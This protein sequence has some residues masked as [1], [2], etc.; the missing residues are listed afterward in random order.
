MKVQDQLQ[1]QDQRIKCGWNRIV[2]PI[3]KQWLATAVS[4]SVH[5]QWVSSLQ[6][7]S[8]KGAVG[9]TQLKSFYPYIGAASSQMYS[10]YSDET[11]YLLELHRPYMALSSFKNGGLIDCLV[12]GCSSDTPRL[13]DIESLIENAAVPEGADIY[14]M[15]THADRVNLRN[16]L[17]SLSRF[18]FKSIEQEVKMPPINGDVTTSEAIM[19][20]G[21]TFNYLT[22]SNQLMVPVQGAE[23]PPPI[24]QRPETK[25]A[26]SVLLFACLIGGVEGWLAVKKNKIDSKLT[27]IEKKVDIQKKLKQDLTKSK[28]AKNDLAGLQKEHASLL[29]LKKMMESVLVTR[30]NFMAEFLDIIVLNI[31]D[32]LLVDSIVEQNWNEFLINGWSLDQASVEYFSQGLSRDLHEWDM[33]IIENPSELERNKNSEF[34]GYKFRLV[35][36]KIPK[37]N[38]K[39]ASSGK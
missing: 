16:E 1:L 29:E 32:N 15:V 4:N 11:T 35:I 21:A 17:E 36:K 10:I 13:D 26:A 33:G 30:N 8:T 31:N 6:A 28:K 19:I 9:K 5:K 37:N 24:L 25:I 27:S 7:V 22:N 3:D 23:P 34:S 20:F 2:N 38:N 39:I 18:Y 14:V 12:L